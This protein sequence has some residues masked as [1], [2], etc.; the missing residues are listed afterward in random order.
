MNAEVRPIR[1]SAEQ[2]L[3]ALIEQASGMFPGDGDVKKLRETAAKSF[4][5]NGLPHRRVEEWKYT[6]LRAL[7]RDAAPHASPP[8][9]NEI[10]EAKKLDPFSGIEARRLVLVNGVFVPELSDAAALEKGLTIVP[11]ARALT[12]GHKLVQRIGELKPDTY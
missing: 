12:E 7:M 4:L 6:D 3:A 2:A 5:E 9:K 11:L 8:G 1:T 10:A